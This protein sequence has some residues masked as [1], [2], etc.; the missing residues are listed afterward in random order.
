MDFNRECL[1]LYLVHA[2]GHRWITDQLAP[3]TGVRQRNVH[4]DHLAGLTG[5]RDRWNPEPGGML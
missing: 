1:G 4:A 2:I 5:V 3:G